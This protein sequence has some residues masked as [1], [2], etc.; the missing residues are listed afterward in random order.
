MPPEG[1]LRWASIACPPARFEPCRQLAVVSPIGSRQ[2][3]L[4]AS[5]LCSPHCHHPLSRCPPPPPPP[6]AAPL[7]VC[8]QLKR[9]DSHALHRCTAGRILP[10]RQHV[11]LLRVPH[12]HVP[13]QLWSGRVPGLPPWFLEWQNRAVCVQHLLPGELFLNSLAQPSALCSMRMFS[14]GRTCASRMQGYRCSPYMQFSCDKGHYSD[15][16]GAV[17]CKPCAPVSFHR[18]ASEKFKACMS[19]AQH[20]AV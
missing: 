2:P 19:L 7:Q 16:P 8:R 17:I 11:E 3:P 10:Q 5:S 6:S 13:A 9:C 15:G 12:R 1:R 20:C 14:P 18:C 4:A